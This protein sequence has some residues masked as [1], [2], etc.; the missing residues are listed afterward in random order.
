MP[1]V[2]LLASTSSGVRAGDGADHVGEAG[3]LRAGG[4]R[5]LAGDADES[6]G[7]M[8][9]RAFV[10]SAEGGD[11][12]RCDGVND[13]VVAGAREER[14]DTFFLARAREDLGAGH[15]KGERLRGCGRGG[16]ELRRYPNG[17]DAA[18]R[19][20]LTGALRASGGRRPPECCGGRGTGAR[21]RVLEEPAT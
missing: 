8:G 1:I 17:R 18:G 19:I 9:H 4:D 15:R 3:P 7:R 2:M 10:P 5:E 11:A 16:G 6:V 14:G 20:L 13:R 21:N 12:G